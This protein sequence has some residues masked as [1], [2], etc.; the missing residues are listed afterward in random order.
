MKM[1]RAHPRIRRLLYA[2]LGWAI[3]VLLGSLLVV[4]LLAPALALRTPDAWQRFI[5]LLVWRGL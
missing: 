4:G 5:E 2:L 3:I 1:L